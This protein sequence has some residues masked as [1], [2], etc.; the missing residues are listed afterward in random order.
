MKYFGGVILLA[1][2]AVS[3]LGWEPFT[4]EERGALPAD[5]RRGPGGTLIWFTGF[6]GG[7]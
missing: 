4:T 1:Y 6:R 5:A 7:K 3:F 2:A